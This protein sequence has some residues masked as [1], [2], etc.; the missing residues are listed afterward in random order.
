MT[1]REVTIPFCKEIRATPEDFEDFQA[2]VNRLENDPE[3][4]EAGV[5]KASSSL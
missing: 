1:A 4:K 3:V 2:F 5:A